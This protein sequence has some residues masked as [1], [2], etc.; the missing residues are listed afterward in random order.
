VQQVIDVARKHN[1]KV[2]ATGRSMI[3]TIAVA[4]ELGYL[5]VPKDTLIDIE[6]VADLPPNKV[7]ILATGAQGEPMAAL[8]LMA[9]QA[10]RVIKIDEGDLVIISATPIPGNEGSV[11]RTVNQF[12]RQGAEVM[13]APQTPVHV[14]GHGNQEDL[15]LMINLA[16]AKYLIPY[17]G[18]FRHLIGYRKLAGSMGVGEDRVTIPRTGQILEVSEAGVKFA[19]DVPTGDVMVD[20]LGIGDIG[21]VVLR[22]R[23]HL[24]EDGFL[25]CVVSLDRMTG[26]VVAGPD[27]ITRGFVYVKTSEEFLDRAR[28]EVVAMLEQLRLAGVTEWT[29]VRSNLREVLSKFAWRE[30][31][32]RPMVVPVVMEV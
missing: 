32:R 15:K 20:G 6:A 30:L 1:R 17:H 18:E 25:L 31:K 16:R 4:Q 19:G 14:S 26:A 22:D 23:L 7:A 12:Y 8:S 10:H 9:R 27:L 24:A 28:T 29:V 3:S 21:T 2:A 11:F 13:Y 5:K